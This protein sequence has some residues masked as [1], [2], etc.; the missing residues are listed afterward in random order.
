MC[1]WPFTWTY[2][3][4][5]SGHGQYRWQASAF[6]CASGYML[7]FHIHW[8]VHICHSFVGFRRS[9]LRSNDIKQRE[10][11]S[12]KVQLAAREPFRAVAK[13][14]YK[15]VVWQNSDRAVND[16]WPRTSPGKPGPPTLRSSS[17]E[18]LRQHEAPGRSCSS[19]D[20][21][22]IN[23]RFAASKTTDRYK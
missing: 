2:T 15:T 4:T 7:E 1:V 22:D 11:D 17:A 10:T 20:G 23:C 3:V 21:A 6:Y 5:G 13:V 19:C 18:P 9:L 8:T 14:R 12:A 16:S